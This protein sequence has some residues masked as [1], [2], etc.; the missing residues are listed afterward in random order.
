MVTLYDPDDLEVT[1]TY[2]VMDVQGQELLVQWVPPVNGSNDTAGTI[3]ENKHVF[4][5]NAAGEHFS[6]E[7]TWSVSRPD[8]LFLEF[9]ATDPQGSTTVLRPR[10][11]L[12]NCMNGGRCQDDMV[13]YS[14]Q[15]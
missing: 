10:V 13:S 7:F 9:T 8:P 14:S 5:S 3:L 2:S 1:F 6:F 11:Q 4:S 15:Y 12:C